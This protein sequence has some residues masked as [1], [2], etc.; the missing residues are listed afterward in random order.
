M[1]VGTAGSLGLGTREEKNLVKSQISLPSRGICYQKRFPLSCF[2]F[3]LLTKDTFQMA[4]FPSHF[5]GVKSVCDCMLSHVQLFVTPWTVVHQ[6]PLSMEF[7][8]QECWNGWPFPSSEDH[9]YPVVKTKSPVFLIW[10]WIP[11]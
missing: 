1:R 6:D 4:N 2:F 10:R 5:S 8:R 9:P 3:F 11:Y 7:S